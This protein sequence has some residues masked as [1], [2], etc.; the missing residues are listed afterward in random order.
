MLT[1]RVGRALLGAAFAALLLLPLGA[2]AQ[3]RSGTVEISPFGGGDFGGRLYAG[4][5]DVFTRDV[6]VR[7]AATYGLRLTYNVNNWLGIEASASRAE[8]DIRSRDLLLDENLERRRVKLGELEA[9]RYELDGVFSFGHRRFRPY[10]ALG[11]G[12]TRFRTEAA[13][14]ATERHTRFTANL[15]FG[16]KLWVTPRFAFRLDGRG[17]AA[18]VNTSRRCS[19]S[20]DEDF[21][22]DGFRRDSNDS[23]RWYGSSELTGGVTFAF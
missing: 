16:M 10:V 22:D 14:F 20:R 18:Y 15:G 21:C 2:S 6:D 12:A 23:R 8:S 11:A 9:W 13:G 7:P 17:R 1:R 5:N 19:D 4:S 3:D